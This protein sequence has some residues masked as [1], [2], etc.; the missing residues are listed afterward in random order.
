[1]SD[2]SLDLEKCYSIRRKTRG[3]TT[4]DRKHFIDFIFDS[5]GTFESK[6]KND[7]SKKLVKA[8][9]DETGVYISPSWVYTI[10]RLGP[11][12]HSDGSYEL[13][14]YKEHTLD[15]LCEHPN[16]AFEIKFSK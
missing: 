2:E 11:V 13:K 12:K 14:Y 3:V 9:E 1:M 5:I 10:I 15:E 4:E 16:I 7:L 6:S 8:F